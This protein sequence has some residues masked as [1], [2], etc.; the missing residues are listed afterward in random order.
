ME[1]H[2]FLFD[3]DCERSETVTDEDQKLFSVSHSNLLVL[4]YLDR[5]VYKYRASSDTVRQTS[6]LFLMVFYTL[7][8]RDT[9]ED[10]T[11][12]P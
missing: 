2:C 10:G 12:V 3:T 6:H 8:I 1:T 7:E 11:G 9:V 5:T 4:I